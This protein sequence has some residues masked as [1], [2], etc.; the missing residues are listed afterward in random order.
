MKPR[1]NQMAVHISALQNQKAQVAVITSALNSLTVSAWQV[2]SRPCRQSPVQPCGVTVAT[3]C[4]GRVE[5]STRC[6]RQL[7]AHGPA[8]RVQSLKAQP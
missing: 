5:V 4:A 1:Q 8:G 2:Q 3:V 6:S 7:P